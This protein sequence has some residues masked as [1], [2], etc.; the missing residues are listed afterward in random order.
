MSLLRVA[1]FKIQRR[2]SLVVL[3]SAPH[4]Y[5]YR[6]S[7]NANLSHYFTNC[8]CC[9]CHCYSPLNRV[10]SCWL[11][12]V[13]TKRPTRRHMAKHVAG[14]FAATDRFLLHCQVVATLLVAQISK[15]ESATKRTA[16][17]IQAPPSMHDRA[18]VLSQWLVLLLLSSEKSDSLGLLWHC[19]SGFCLIALNLLL[20][21]FPADTLYQYSIKALR[22]MLPS[23]PSVP[24]CD[25]LLWESIK[26]SFRALSLNLVL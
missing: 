18:R 5:R 10:V 25:A 19:V 9:Y 22:H 20:P 17:P 14:F 21:V 15:G 7:G 13:K 8:C 24:Q 6:L 1:A 23:V 16:N 11:S 3:L 26:C 4:H 12:A 2:H